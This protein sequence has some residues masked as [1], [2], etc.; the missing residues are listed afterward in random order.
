VSE[1]SVGDWCRRLVSETRVGDW[2]RIPVTQTGVGDLCRR[3]SE[4]DVGAGFQPCARV[5]N[6]SA[7]RSFAAAATS[8]RLRGAALV[9]NESISLRATAAVSL[10]ARSNAASF[11]FEG[12]LNP[13][14]LRTN[15]SDAARI[16]SSVAGGSKLKS[17][18]MFRHIVSSPW[19]FDIVSRFERNFPAA[20]LFDDGKRHI[21]PS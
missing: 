14:S 9:D 2:C 11:A 17:V 19:V 3:V 20:D 12:A 21:D 1:T 5:P 6:R 13:L 18:L 16:S 7:D 15:C 10:M 8:S 4:A